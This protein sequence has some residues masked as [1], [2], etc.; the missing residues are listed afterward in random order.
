VIARARS[1]AVISST[2]R[3]SR[4]SPAI[5]IRSQ[6]RALKRPLMDAVPQSAGRHGAQVPQAV[7]SALG[8][9]DR[10]TR[11]PLDKLVDYLADDVGLIV[12]DNCEHLLTAC[13]GFLARLLHR[14]RSVR[15]LETSNDV[16]VIRCSRASTP[17]GGSA[18]SLAAPRPASVAPPTATTTAMPVPAT[19]VVPAYRCSTGPR[20]PPPCSAPDP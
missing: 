19:T 10:T 11:P 14:T 6:S 2:G 18:T 15:V 12:L 3:S 5:Q 13:A 16:A 20:P 4:N 7:V 17:P 9:L 8:L 1:V